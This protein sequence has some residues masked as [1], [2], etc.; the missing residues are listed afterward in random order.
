MEGS[1]T[2]LAVAAD[3]TSSDGTTATW[4]KEPLPLVAFEPP[5]MPLLAISTSV[6][7]RVTWFEAK[8]R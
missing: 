5:A 4:N 1:G 6:P 7:A 8:P 3:E 2:S